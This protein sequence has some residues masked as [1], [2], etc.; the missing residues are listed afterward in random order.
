MKN[1]QLMAI[2]WQSCVDFNRRH[3]VGSTVYTPNPQEGKPPRKGVIK[4]EAHALPSG[5]AVVI[6]ENDNGVT[7]IED[8]CEANG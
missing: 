8:L 3:P 2:A 7:N 4:Q 1:D 6:L 5:Q